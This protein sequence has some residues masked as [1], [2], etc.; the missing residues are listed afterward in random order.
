MDSTHESTHVSGAEGLVILLTIATAAIH[1]Y[2]V[3]GEFSK[4]ATGY[5]TA[6][7]L[8]GAGYLIALALAFWPGSMPSS[9][10]VLG[11]LAVAGIAIAAII[12]YLSLGYF[13]TLGWVTKS[14]EAV[15]VLSVVLLLIG[16][17]HST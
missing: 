6:F 7:I 12:A 3:P 14:I 16:S 1:F 13:D 15:L 11:K 5:G 8:T 9:L 2:L 17:D 4:G 10:H